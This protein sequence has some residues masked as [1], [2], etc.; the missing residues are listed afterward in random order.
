ME[1][2]PLG[3]WAQ[4]LLPLTDHVP[5]LQAIGKTDALFEG[6]ELQNRP[7]GQAR[8]VTDAD[9]EYVPGAQAEQKTGENAP[10]IE[11]KVPAGQA[12]QEEALK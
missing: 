1:K 11:E 12:T 7:A 5:A 8:Q 3:H 4:T 6:I 9:V 10:M 2:V